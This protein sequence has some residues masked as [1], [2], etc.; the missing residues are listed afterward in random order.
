MLTYIFRRILGMIP[1]LL[2]L[3]IIVFS[4]A[5]M[6]PGDALTG[7]IDPTNSSPQYIAE[8]REK[9]GYNDSL[10][11]QYWHWMKGM[12]HGN[13]GDSFMHKLPVSNMIA[14]RLPNTLLLA[15]MSLIITYTAAFIMGMIAGRYPNSLADKAIIS[16]NYIAYAIPSFVAAIIA[17]YIF[18]IKLGWVP[19]SGTVDVGADQNGILYALSRIKHAVLPALTLGLF[20]TASYTQFLRN[21]IIE[22]SRKDFVRT[23]R[24]KGTHESKI[25]NRHILRNSL[26]PLVTFFGFDIAGLI[27]GAIIIETIFVYPGMGS[28]FMNSIANRDYSVVM[29]LTMLLSTMTLMGNLI[30]DLLYG[31]VD[32]RIRLE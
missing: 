6:M 3:S 9:L 20:S 31:V 10:P 14:E 17:I 23:A 21:D 18:A 16:A 28:L 29:T 30:S 32:P 13:F 27:G 19:I 24:A 1:M 2:L 26:I 8:M 25:Y 11:V 4:L 15:V 12:L 7:K 5:K 22:S